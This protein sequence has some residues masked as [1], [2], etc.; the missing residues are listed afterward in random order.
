MALHRRTNICQGWVNF[1]VDSKEFKSTQE[2]GLFVE[3][4]VRE[5]KYESCGV[6]CGYGNIV[7]IYSENLV[8]TDKRKNSDN[9]AEMIK[10]NSVNQKF[11]LEETLYPYM[12]DMDGETVYESVSLLACV[13]MGST[14]WS[15]YNQ[16]KGMWRC[17]YKDLNPDGQ[18]MYNSFKKLYK[19]AE[20]IL[21]TWLDT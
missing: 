7:S 18:A 8:G 6:C 5:K 15:G 12:Y 13:T 19:N 17:T 14:G 11:A 1:P 21:V 10:D 20:L 2:G 16:K 9:S 3:L 4:W